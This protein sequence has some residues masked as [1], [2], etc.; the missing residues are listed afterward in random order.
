MAKLSG[1]AADIIERGNDHHARSI[2]ND[3]ID[4]SSLLKGADVATFTAD[5]TTLHFIAGDCPTVLTGGIS[6]VGSGITL[7]SRGNDLFGP[8]FGLG[9]ETI[10]VLLDAFADF[11]GQ[12]PARCDQATMEPASSRDMPLISR[13]LLVCSS[14]DSSTSFKRRSYCSRRS[15]SFF[16]DLIDDLF[17][18]EQGLLLLVKRFFPL[19]NPAF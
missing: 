13:S 3:H 11:L 7:D 12:F 6:S 14:R 17:F 1:L 19:L 15:G 2:V 5:D 9:L 4:A 8:S 16:L 10:F 18:L